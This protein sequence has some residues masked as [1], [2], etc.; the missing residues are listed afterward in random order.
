M[1]NKIILYIAI[2]LDGFI[3]K[4]DGSLDW[5]TRYEN[6][7]EDYG[8]KELYNRIGTVL[9]GGTTYRQ[10]EDAYKGKEAYVFTRKE[11]K[12]KADN[13]HFVSGDVKEVLN[14]L[15]L[16]Y[17]KNIWLV[18]GAALANQFLSADLIDEYI[19]TIIPKLLGKGISL[20]QGRNPESNLE[21]LNV[22]SYDSGLV[23]LHY[24]RHA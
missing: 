23:Q 6:S 10:I 11:P 2:S 4:E 16:G 12:Q 17:N 5:L 15:K 22:K 9:V 13:I 14:N 19:I 24:V 20:F 1:N 18:G 21:L 8:F 7:G 3:A